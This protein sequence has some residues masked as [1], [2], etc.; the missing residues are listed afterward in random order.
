M[1]KI[2]ILSV[3]DYVEHLEIMKDFLEKAGF[4][5]EITENRNKLLPESIN[6]YDVFLDYTHGGSLTEEQTQSIVSFVKNGKALVG[7]HSSAVDKGSVEFIKLLGGKYAGHS[8]EAKASVRVIDRG[9]PITVGISDFDIVD[10][11]YKLSDCDTSTFTTLI[12]SD[13]HGETHPVLWVK[14]YGKGK[15]AFLSLGH[16]APAFNNPSFQ[17]LVIRMVKWATNTL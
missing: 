3:V 14:E 4:D 10:E 15:V 12:E 1:S 16:G 6:K 17:A 5:I 11:I 13:V 7:V 9:H 2:K 8:D